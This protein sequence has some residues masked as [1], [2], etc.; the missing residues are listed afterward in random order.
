MSLTDA[1]A[2]PV[3]TP[4]TPEATDVNS[5]GDKPKRKPQRRKL[6]SKLAENFPSYLQVCKMIQTYK[7]IHSFLL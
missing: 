3:A 2:T 4:T 6:K 5:L 7:L 1:D